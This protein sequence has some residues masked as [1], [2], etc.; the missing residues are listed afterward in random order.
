MTVSEL[1]ALL[2]PLPQDATVVVNLTKNE[3]AN[4]RTPRKVR[5]VDAV[6]TA[7]GD[8]RECWDESE[9]E[10]GDQF[11]LWSEGDFGRRVVDVTA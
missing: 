6:G 9:A 11:G 8:Y 3:F 1:I 5:E 2:T 10:S 4:G 7:E